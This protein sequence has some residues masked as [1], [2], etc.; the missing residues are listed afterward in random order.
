MCSLTAFRK[1]Q[2]DIFSGLFGV[3]CCG[4]LRVYVCRPTEIYEW[5][6]T[7][8]QYTGLVCYDLEMS[9]EFVISA[10]QII[11]F[12]QKVIFCISITVTRPVHP[13]GIQHFGKILGGD[14]NVT[15]PESMKVPGLSAI[16]IWKVNILLCKKCCTWNYLTKIPVHT[17]RRK[18]LRKQTLS[19][20]CKHSYVQLQMALKWFCVLLVT[21][22]SH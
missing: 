22:G 7:F 16:R 2:C 21:F 10:H 11:F 4:S 19:K 6:N 14:F 20:L 17:S 9:S 13:D 8:G 3:A 5:P 1:F 12:W 18:P 15:R